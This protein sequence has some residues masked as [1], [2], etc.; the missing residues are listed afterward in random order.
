MP[1]G[2]E[3]M[4]QEVGSV[5]RKAEGAGNGVRYY[6]MPVLGGEDSPFLPV[7]GGT[8]NL[9][10][11]WLIDSFGQYKEVG[12][13]SHNVHIS[14]SLQGENEKEVLLRPR[15]LQ[16]VRIEFEWMSAEHEDAA[17]FDAASTP[18]T[19]FLVPVFLDHCIY[20]YDNQGRLSGAIMEG[21][22]QPCWQPG[23]GNCITEKF[24]KRTAYRE[25]G[26]YESVDALSQEVPLG[27]GG[28]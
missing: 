4:G 7:R 18:V 21:K 9:K 8:L 10:R 17:S 22:D 13:F 2:Y 12:I 26:R 19:G 28:G 25:D 16:P 23:M 3:E 1:A 11:L 14:E 27:I 5:G 6:H 20:V 15:F 24:C